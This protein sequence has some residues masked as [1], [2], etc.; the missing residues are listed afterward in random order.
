MYVVGSSCL[1]LVQVWIGKCCF[2]Y[3]VARRGGGGEVQV[4]FFSG[5]IGKEGWMVLD[6]VGGW[7]YIKLNYID[8]VYTYIVVDG[9]C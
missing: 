3:V 1:G 4:E 7:C 8:Y 2:F 5:Y 9:R 6:V